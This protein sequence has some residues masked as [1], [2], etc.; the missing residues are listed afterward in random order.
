M[1]KFHAVTTYLILVMFERACVT[2]RP[3]VDA[4]H[5]F[6]SD[7]Q[8]DSLA[9]PHLFMYCDYRKRFSVAN[10]G[11]KKDS[12]KVFVSNASLTINGAGAQG[13]RGQQKRPFDF[14]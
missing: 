2:F 3:Q 14:T 12:M 11:M 4:L 7:R 10:I 13:V 6:S 5:D 1:Q 8:P 9:P